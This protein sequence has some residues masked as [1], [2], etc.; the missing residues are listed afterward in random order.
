MF[1]DSITLLSPDP[2]ALPAQKKQ[3]LIL[4]RDH[5]NSLKQCLCC[6]PLSTVYWWVTGVALRGALCSVIRGGKGCEQRQRCLRGQA[7]NNDYKLELAAGATGC[8]CGSAGLWSAPRLLQSPR[9]PR[10]RRRWNYVA[11]CGKE[12]DATPGWRS[13]EDGSAG[14]AGGL[15]V[16]LCR[17]PEGMAQWDEGEGTSLCA[18]AAAVCLRSLVTH[19]FP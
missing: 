4:Q 7:F 16:R 19:R 15:W 14:P 11:A 2:K 6:V 17:W 1:Y 10:M 9:P 3:P 8:S 5:H 18:L 13:K 12:C